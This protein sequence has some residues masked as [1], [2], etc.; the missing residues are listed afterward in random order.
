MVMRLIEKNEDIKKY[1]KIS[2][3]KAKTF[4]SCKAKYHFCYIE[5]LPR[6]QQ[7]FHVFGTFNHEVLERFHLELMKDPSLN[8]GQLMKKCFKE[9]YLN[10][11]EPITKEQLDQ[12]NSILKGYLEL[13]DKDGLPDVTDVEKEF[14]ILIDDKLVLTGFIDRVQRDKDGLIHVADYKTS[15]SD[16]ELKKDFFQ[17]ETYAF[18]LMLAD[19]SIENIRASYI[20][21]RHNF[22][23]ITKEFKRS[24]I[25]NI[26]NKFL[27]YE[28]LISEERLWRAEPQFLCKY[29]DYLEHCDEGKG[30]LIKIGLKKQVGKGSW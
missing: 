26:A 7:D 20:M 23:F 10:T 3:S 16:R 22:N 27:D 24:D 14:N 18:A 15:K 12:S 9:S 2:V 11:K 28:K 30:H 25:M 17:L 1:F 5:K 6:I 13:L 8:R 21:L 19:E 29:C 4:D